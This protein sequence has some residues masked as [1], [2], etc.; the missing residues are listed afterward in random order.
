[1]C[2]RDSSQRQKILSPTDFRCTFSGV[3][4]SY[5]DFIGAI[6]DQDTE[7]AGFLFG[8]SIQ[9]KDLLAIVDWILEQQEIYRNAEWWWSENSINRIPGIGQD[10]SYG[11]AYQLL[12]YKKS[13]PPAPP[14]RYEVHSSYGVDE[15]KEIQSVLS[16]TRE[17]NAILVGNDNA[18]KLRIISVLEELILEGNVS[19]SLKHKEVVLLDVDLFVAE[20]SIKEHF[21]TEI[22]GIMK[23][24]ISAGNIILVIEKMP[25]FIK[26]ASLLGIDLPSLLESYLSSPHLQIIGL[27]DTESFHEVIEKNVLLMQYFEKIIVKEIDDSNTIKVLENE[28]IRFEN[29]GL[30]FTY[31]ALVAIAESAERYFSDGVMPD[32]AID[33]L[34]EIVPRLQSQKKQ[35]VERNDIF[36]MIESKTGIPTSGVKVDEKDKL[37]HLEDILHKKIIGQDAAI[38]TISNA[39]RR[40]RSGLSSPNRPLGS[41]LFL[42]PTGVGKTE[43]SKA[44]NEIF[45]GKEGQ[46]M[47][48]DMSEYSSYEA[49]SKLIGSFESGHPGV[50]SSMLREHQ[51][52]VLLLDEFEKT[53][54]EVMNLFLQIID[55][56]FF[57]DGLGKKVNARNLIIIAT[58]NAGSN[59]IWEE[60]KAGRDL[61]QSKDKIIDSV[62]HDGIFKPELL[63]RFDGVVIFHPLNV[64]HLKK[65]AALMLQKLHSRMAEKG[66]D[67]VID[68]NLVDYVAKEGSDPQFG[69]RPL[70]RVIQEKIEQI[71][72]K[73]IIE[74]SIKQGSQLVLHPEDL[75]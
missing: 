70:N 1:M 23:N 63:N 44:L 21:E 38:S 59:L 67:L 43:T 58:S 54:K 2:I 51:Y 55:E 47:R 12:K 24:A 34:M 29:D 37:L 52:G 17:A 69:A 41:F 8:Y 10:W 31:P 42:G 40:A 65:I 62:I 22:S 53:T 30:F 28:L 6:F 75:V 27:S 68:Q 46:I 71:V 60:M 56:G 33:L 25:S 20:N 73:K 48:L 64:E 45:F 11:K 57:S 3:S 36:A 5:D 66:I 14:E 32:K 19:N 13:L 35:V 74:G 4:F 50:L 16:R 26:S 7:F 61:V 49:T 39:V 72:A 15:L 9:K 18:G